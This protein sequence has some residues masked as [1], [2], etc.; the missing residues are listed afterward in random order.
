LITYFILPLFLVPKSRSVAQN[1]WKKEPIYEYF[2]FD[3]KINKFKQ[4]KRKNLKKLKVAGNYPN[5]YFTLVI[6]FFY[7]KNQN[8]QFLQGTAAPY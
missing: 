8:N 5:I 4:K 3:S 7:M 6:Q 1:E 2:T